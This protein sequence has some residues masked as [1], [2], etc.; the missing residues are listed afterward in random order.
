MYNNYFVQ[1]IEVVDYFDFQ[2]DCFEWG[3]VFAYG[4]DMYHEY[5]RGVWFSAWGIRED[6]D[7][8]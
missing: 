4:Y 8:I 6:R 2:L 5:N 3:G 1:Y 7:E